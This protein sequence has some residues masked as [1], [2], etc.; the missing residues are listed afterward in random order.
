MMTQLYT[1]LYFDFAKD[2]D[3]NYCSHCK[4]YTRIFPTCLHP[5]KLSKL[6]LF[7]KCQQCFPGDSHC[8]HCGARGYNYEIIDNDKDSSLIEH[9]GIKCKVIQGEFIPC[10]NRL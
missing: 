2:K 7:T 1:Q 6:V 5:H 8:A 3:P 10:S 4:G 9:K